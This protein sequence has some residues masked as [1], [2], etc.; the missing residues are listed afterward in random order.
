MSCRA[1]VATDGPQLG[2][3]KI[4]KLF[5]KNFFEDFKREL[6]PGH[7]IKKFDKCNFDVRRAPACC[8]GLDR[9]AHVIFI[10]VCHV[11]VGTSSRSGG[12]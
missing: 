2:K 1:E 3:P 7:V 4:A 12:G 5:N 11:L 6:G 9:R 8:S 10:V